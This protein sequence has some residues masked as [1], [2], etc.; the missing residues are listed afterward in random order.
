M[1][2]C[3]ILAITAFSAYTH[4]YKDMQGVIPVWLVKNN[5]VLK[6]SSVLGDIIIFQRHT[7]FLSNMYVTIT[8]ILVASCLYT[9]VCNAE[10]L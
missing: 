5:L 8:S 10:A 7:Y 3:I 4:L 2:S 1:F 6:V 9:S